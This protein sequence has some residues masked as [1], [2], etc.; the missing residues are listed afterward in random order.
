MEVTNKGRIQTLMINLSCH[1]H[2]VY[3]PMTIKFFHFAFL[4]VTSFQ[5]H[6]LLL[7]HPVVI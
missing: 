1:G 7:A 6:Q 5:N 2:G 4:N 3:V